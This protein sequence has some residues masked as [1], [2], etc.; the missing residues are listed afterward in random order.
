MGE[1]AGS[2]DGAALPCHR[3]AQVRSGS[4]RVYSGSQQPVHYLGRLPDVKV[5]CLADVDVTAIT[6]VSSCLNPGDTTDGIP[7]LTDRDHYK[8]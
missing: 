6:G 3:A 7:V 2:Q 1:G 4:G 8:R 5:R